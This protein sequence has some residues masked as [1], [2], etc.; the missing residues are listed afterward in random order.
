MADKINPSG[1]KGLG[2]NFLPNFFK[3]DANK[4]FIQ[5]TVDQLMQPGTVKKVNGFV[6]REYAKATT[7]S[8]IFWWL[9][10]FA[11]NTLS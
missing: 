3:T 10:T 9:E 1:N 5:A 11:P 7:G 8:D 6:G 4:R 2:I